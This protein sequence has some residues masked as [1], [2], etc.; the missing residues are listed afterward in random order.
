[1][2]IVENTEQ[3]NGD[4]SWHV[5]APLAYETK[6][7][8]HSETIPRPLKPYHHPQ[9]S[10]LLDGERRCHSVIRFTSSGSMSRFAFMNSIS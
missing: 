8:P 4:M 3:C 7:V 5:Q 2:C 1:M 6:G 10:Q 9:V